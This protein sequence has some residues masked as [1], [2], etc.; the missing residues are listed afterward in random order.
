MILVRKRRESRDV[1]EQQNAL[2]NELYLTY[3]SDY[4]REDKFTPSLF[5]SG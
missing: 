2:R 5:L 4:T 3:L 1:T